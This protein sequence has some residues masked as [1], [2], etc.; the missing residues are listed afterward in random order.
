MRQLA[1]SETL[2]VGIG[3][4]PALAESLESH[5]ACDEWRWEFGIPTGFLGI[6]IHD[7][8][9]FTNCRLLYILNDS[10]QPLITNSPHDTN[11]GATKAGSTHPRGRSMGE[12]MHATSMLPTP[13]HRQISAR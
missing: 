7:L 4:I 5:D 3:P 13:G 8:P 9:T 6:L 1:G 2:L 11:A 10:R 12:E